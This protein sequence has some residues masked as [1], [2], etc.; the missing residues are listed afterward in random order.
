MVH[1]TTVLGKRSRAG[2]PIVKTSKNTNKPATAKD[3]PSMRGEDDNV[4]LVFM[5]NKATEEE[6]E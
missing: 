5:P 2:T 3:E 6:R 1:N 4:D